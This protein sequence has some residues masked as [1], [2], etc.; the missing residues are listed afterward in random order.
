MGH[1]MKRVILSVSLPV[2]LV[3][4]IDQV[5]ANQG[6]DRSSVIREALIRYRNSMTPKPQSEEEKP[7]EVKETK[8]EEKKLETVKAVS[9]PWYDPNFYKNWDTEVLKKYLTMNLE[10]DMKKA[11]IE[12]LK[13]RRVM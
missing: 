1:S 8:P 3:M 10:E 9:N 2:D 6:R 7:S 13:R 11:I 4:W 12:E 5:A